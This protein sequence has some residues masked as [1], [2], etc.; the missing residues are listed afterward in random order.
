MKSAV[1]T[2][3]ILVALTATGIVL[4]DSNVDIR[5]SANNFMEAGT[6]V[7]G[8]NQSTSMA[9][10]GLDEVSDY[11]A[12]SE[13][14]G[15]SI[16][17]TISPNGTVSTLGSGTASTPEVYYNNVNIE[18][19][20][21][22]TYRTNPAIYAPALVTTINDTCMGSASFGLSIPGF[23][24]TTSTSVV[25]EEC[26]RRLDAREFRELGMPD[27]AMALLCQTATNQA[28]AD[29]AGYNCNGTPKTGAI[30]SS[31]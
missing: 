19:N 7:Q 12:S 30:A 3:A 1:K 20:G 9:T 23:G 22:S 4:A 5:F 10:T 14:S 21:T 27:V 24:L 31:K 13:E 29:S 8:G 2:M 25:N 17:I 26:V 11:S 28:A 15:Q 6:S 16:T 18:E